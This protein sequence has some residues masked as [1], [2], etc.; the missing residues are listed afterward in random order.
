MY[1]NM[2]LVYFRKFLFSINDV[3]FEYSIYF[4]FQIFKSV[5]EKSSTK[6]VFPRCSQHIF[7]NSVVP[8]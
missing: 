3:F 8:I 6:T 5:N 2:N 4:S 7:M 1:K